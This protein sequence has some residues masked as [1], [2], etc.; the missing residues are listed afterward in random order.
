V[1]ITGVPVDVE[2]RIESVQGFSAH[3]D[4]DAMLEFVDAASDTLDRVF[5]V[6]GEPKSALFLVQRVRD[7]L[8]VDAIAPERGKV[9]EIDF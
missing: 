7:Y 5:V 8:D 2:A 9:Y 4:A 6:H 1:T 3:K